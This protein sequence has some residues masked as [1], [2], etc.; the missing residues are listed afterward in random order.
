MHVNNA[1]MCVSMSVRAYTVSLRVVACYEV[2]GVRVDG[3]L[4]HDD[5]PSVE[6]VCE[7]PVSRVCV[8]LLFLPVLDSRAI[9][10]VPRAIWEGS[11]MLSGPRNSP[12]MAIVVASSQLL[13]SDLVPVRCSL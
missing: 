1:H 6:R 3:L 5:A 4:V 11:R 10:R 9:V 8:G 13:G 12:R 2:P 7:R